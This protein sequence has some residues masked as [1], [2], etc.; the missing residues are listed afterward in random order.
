MDRE[1]ALHSYQEK[2]SRKVE[3]FKAHMGEYILDHGEY[4]ESVVKD[5]AELL[6]EQMK[7]QQK[8]YVCFMYFSMLRTDLINRNYRLYFHGLDMRWYMDE[9]PLE[10]YVEAEELFLPLEELWKDLESENQ[11]YGGMVNRYDIQNIILDQL[12]F[13]DSTICQILRYR[14]RDWEEKGIFDSIVRTPY[15][16]LKWGEYRDQ[17]EILIQ[18]DRVEKEITVW[19]DETARAAHDPEALV[20]SYWYKG[21]YEEKTLRSVDMRFI[22]FEECSLINIE[23]KDCN[24]EGCRILG[25]KLTGCS[26]QGCN[27]WG[28]DFRRC[29]FEGCDFKGAELTAAIFP[30]QSVPYLNISAEQL[31]VIR[32]DRGDGH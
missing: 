3:K 30:E 13:I 16:I 1:T 28:A 11:G 15:W 29:S 32:I 19:K 14:L 4:M 5:A 23:F 18:T 10:V 8:E 9:E 24:M 12:G 26:F 21:S 20:F 6:G 2:A 27:L 25:T 7:K 17:S 31:Q 22:T